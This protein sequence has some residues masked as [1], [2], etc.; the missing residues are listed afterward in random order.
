[1][2]TSQA[3]QMHIITGVFCDNRERL[4]ALCFGP[5]TSQADH[6]DA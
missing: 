4:H 6:I 5:L 2:A 1:M 3:L